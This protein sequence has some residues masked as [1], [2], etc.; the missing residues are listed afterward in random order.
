MRPFWLCTPPPRQHNIRCV[1][2]G[3]FVRVITIASLCGLTGF[4][5]AGCTIYDGQPPKDVA[6]QQAELQAAS[7]EA[8][9]RSD[10]VLPGSTAYLECRTNL[11]NQQVLAEQPQNP[12][13]GAH[14]YH[15]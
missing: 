1:G 12:F 2:R 13:T 11:D 14:L 7:D 3:L 8:Q 15:R 4:L 10:G 5:L 9:C 6:Q